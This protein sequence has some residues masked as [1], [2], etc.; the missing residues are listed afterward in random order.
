MILCFIS[1]VVG[2]VTATL[3]S[4]RPCSLTL[5]NLKQL[6]HR[7]LQ[8]WWM[9]WKT[10]L[11][12][13]NRPSSYPS[14]WSSASYVSLCELHLNVVEI[15]LDVP[16]RPEHCCSSTTVKPPSSTYWPT[17]QIFILRRFLHRLSIPAY[18]S[19]FQTDPIRNLMHVYG[20]A[21]VNRM[22]IEMFGFISAFLQVKKENSRIQSHVSQTGV[23]ALG[24]AQ[25]AG[26]S[27]IA[28][29]DARSW[30]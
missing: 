30:S 7:A 27:Y 15:N 10:F 21:D 9:I 13:I 8:I 19:I 4:M 20:K 16:S 14:D 1:V 23:T 12:Y 17:W 25:Y 22:S 24:C 3:Y 26:L 2:F 18:R 6:H 11:K 29:E 5:L 28:N